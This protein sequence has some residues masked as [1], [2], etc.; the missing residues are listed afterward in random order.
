MTRVTELRIGPEGQVAQ[1]AYVTGR[2]GTDHPV[3][4]GI[5]W[6]DG[7]L[8]LHRYTDDEVSDWRPIDLQED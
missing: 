7:L 2:Y 1:H 5:S 4:V 3:W 6:P 8:T